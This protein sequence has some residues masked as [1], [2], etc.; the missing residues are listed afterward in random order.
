MHNS[1]TVRILYFIVLILLLVLFVYYARCYCM[2]AEHLVDPQIYTSGATMRILGTQFTSTDQ[3]SDDIVYND[4][5]KNWKD[6]KE[7]FT[8]PYKKNSIKTLVRG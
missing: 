8:I 2:S 7:K 3:G 6:Y 4:E 5:L 1:P